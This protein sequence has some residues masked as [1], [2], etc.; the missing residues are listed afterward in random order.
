MLIYGTFLFITLLALA[1]IGID[2]IRWFMLRSNLQ[3]AIAA[4]AAAGGRTLDQK[5]DSIGRARKVAE[6]VGNANIAA[7]LTDG[8]TVATIVS[9][10]FYSAMPSTI[11]ALDAQAKFIRVTGTAQTTAFFPLTPFA[12]LTASSTAVD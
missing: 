1:G 9:V 12:V 5:Q 6:E 10:T 3:F 8:V 11:T 4:A 2:G 7:T